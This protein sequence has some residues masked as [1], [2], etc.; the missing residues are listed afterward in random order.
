MLT[1]IG[2]FRNTFSD[3]FTK[4]TE[5]IYIKG[6]GNLKKIPNLKKLKEK[7]EKHMIGLYDKTTTFMHSHEILFGKRISLKNI[8]K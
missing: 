5:K 7:I 1:S 3:A 6:K 8:V 2:S 4:N